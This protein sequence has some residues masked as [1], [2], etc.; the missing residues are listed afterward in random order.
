MMNLD[1]A[2]MALIAA[3]VIISLQGFKNRAFLD[4]WT[5]EVGKILGG[6]EYYRIIS[7]GFVHVDGNHLL[8]NMLSLFFFAGNIERSLGIEGL[9]AVYFGSLLAGSLFSLVVH[10]NS[11]GYRAVGASG[12][13]SGIVFAAIALFPG[14]KLGLLFLP[15]FFPAWVFG[16]GFVAY[17][18][19][20]I[21]SQRDNVGHE[22]HLGGAIVGLLIALLF[23]PQAF[24]NN[25]FTILLIFIPTA[26]FMII[27]WQKPQWLFKRQAQ[28]QTMDDSYNERQA[29]LK[30][31][32][33]R[34]LEKVNTHGADSLTHQE[35]EFL[36]HFR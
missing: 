24:F 34:I 31:E 2:S 30:A 23:D 1:M 13:V 11:P 12:A 7:S 4:K 3:N 14:M 17:S 26:I 15:S 20:G 32:L 9:L 36:N 28:P 6:K 16:L 21:R 22:A 18:I 8:F 19:Y 27:A 5:F 25:T 35:R 10:R 33:N 29:Q